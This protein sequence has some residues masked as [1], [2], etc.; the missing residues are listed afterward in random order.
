MKLAYADPPYPG[1]GWRYPERQ[2]V[3]HGELIGHLQTFDGWALSTNSTTLRQVLSICPEGVRVGAWV[4][5]WCAWKKG[6]NP[7]YAWEP[8]I[9]RPGRKRLGFTTRDWWSGSVTLRRAVIG[10]KPEG[11][12][13]WVL[14]LL[15]Y[16]DGDEI[17]DLYPGTGVLE[18]VRAQ[19]RLL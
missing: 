1:K 14:Q 3:D 16:E 2:E 4:K 6:V 11:F 12:M 19:G 17:V 10:A 7:V 5:P 18:R 8:V 13:E 15:G 9:F